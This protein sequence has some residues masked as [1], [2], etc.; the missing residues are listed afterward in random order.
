MS[1]K[2]DDPK[3]VLVDVQHDFEPLPPGTFD[4][5]QDI[6][7]NGFPL[8]S[9]KTEDHEAVNEMLD[10]MEKDRLAEEARYKEPGVALDTLVKVITRLNQDIEEGR[11]QQVN[12]VL[13]VMEVEVGQSCNHNSLFLK[14]R[15]Y[16]QDGVE[17]IIEYASWSDYGG[18][19]TPPD[20]EEYLLWEG[21]D[22]DGKPI[23]YQRFFVIG[24]M[25]DRAAYGLGSHEQRK[26]KGEWL[27]KVLRRGDVRCRI[28]TD[29]RGCASLE[30][31][32]T[33]RDAAYKAIGYYI[34]HQK[35]DSAIFSMGIH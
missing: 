6:V 11:F 2:K 8:H 19:E 33:A 23:T 18:R 32:E 4:D 35:D 14:A 34:A 10:E 29:E 28:H 22:D 16:R 20:G 15:C 9:M 21:L 26:K 3:V 7:E 1:D 27:F 24:T 31:A 13:E 5:S 12:Q 17:D 30:V 25:G